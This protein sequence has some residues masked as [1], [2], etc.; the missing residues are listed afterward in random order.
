MTINDTLSERAKRYGDFRQQAQIAQEVKRAMSNSPNWLT[1]D[2]DQREALELIAGKVGRILNGDA[3]YSDSWHDIAGY[4]TLIEK[5]LT[6]PTPRELRDEPAE[7]IY[8]TGHPV[9][10]DF[11][12]GR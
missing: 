2:D 6:A 5:R 4:A 9:P 8:A 7:S 11:K 12:N 10:W 3:N 1:L